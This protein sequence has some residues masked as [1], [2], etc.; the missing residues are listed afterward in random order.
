MMDVIKII[1]KYYKENVALRD[2]LLI[3][4]KAVTR[5]A[6]N[7]ADKHP[8]LKLDRTFMHLPYNVL[9]QCHTSV[10]G[11]SAQKC[12]ARKD[13]HGMQESASDI[14]APDC[15][16]M[17]YWNKNCHCH[18]ATCSLKHWKNRSSAMPTS[19]S[20]RRDSTT[21]RPSKKPKSRSGSLATEAYCASG[22]GQICSNRTPTQRIFTLTKHSICSEQ[23][24]TKKER[25]I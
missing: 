1:D 5:R 2:I 21:K 14:Q 12:C 13:C 22:N 11:C 24:T 8:E 23:T 25:C 20:R 15:H 18:T 9:E 16:W 19:S 7:I 3:H 10:M 6:L 17:K 4:S